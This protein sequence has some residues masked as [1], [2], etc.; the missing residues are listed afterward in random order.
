MV[1]GKASPDPPAKAKT[2]AVVFVSPRRSQAV[3]FD[4]SFIC[5]VGHAWRHRQLQ[6]EFQK[7]P[8]Q[9]SSMTCPKIGV[10]GEV[11]GRLLARL[12]KH[13]VPAIR[14]PLAGPR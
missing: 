10:G 2:G 14:R 4:S 8:S 1:F 3:F 7:S 9:P 6:S 13:R 5:S 12:A 11:C